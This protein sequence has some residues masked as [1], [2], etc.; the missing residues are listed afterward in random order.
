MA[1]IEELV[2]WGASELNESDSARIDAEI[3]LAFI[4]EKNR[5]YLYTWSDR[6]VSAESESRFR[7]LIAKRTAGEPVA[8]LVG[9]QPFWNFELKVTPATLIPRSETELLVELALERI[10]QEEALRVVDLGTGTGAIALAIASERPSVEVIATDFSEH[11]LNIARENAESLGLNRVEFRHGSWLGP[12]LVESQPGQSGQFEQFD[13]I[14]SNPPYVE[15]DSPYL[16]R[17]DLR[18]EPDSAL[19]GTDGDGLGDIREIVKHAPAHLKAHGWLLLEHGAEQGSAVRG[20]FA[21]VGFDSVETVK[22]LAG[23]DRVTMGQISE[24]E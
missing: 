10:P 7:T 14:L 19:I 23:L 13:L 1:T 22:D 24:K 15:P 11:A 3:I 16:Q 4:I 18:F 2:A 21:V 20:I 8:Y 9:L 12:L 17:G 5:T 6:A